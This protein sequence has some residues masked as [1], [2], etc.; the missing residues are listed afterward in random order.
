MLRYIENSG[1]A[2][3]IPGRTQQRIRKYKRLVDGFIMQT[4][5]NPSDKEICRYMEISYAELVNI[6]KMA[7]AGKVES[8]DRAIMANGDECTIGDIIPSDIDIESSVL[9]KIQHEQLKNI[10]WTAVSALPAIQQQV[11][12]ARYLEGKT[13]KE[14]GQRI[15]ATTGQ[16]RQLE[17][18]AL[19]G[20]ERS[21]RRNMLLA[22]IPEYAY[23]HN[24][25][26]E[27]NRTWTSST[28]FA[29]FKLHEK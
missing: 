9:D 8:L 29:A 15:G 19:R 12:R 4:G 6:R 28:E 27:F 14:I 2:S 1:S 5:R 26:A 20:M 24:S 3:G 23:R 17:H 16:A 11:I 25:V 10:I 22:F 21:R 13:L 7:E 18:K